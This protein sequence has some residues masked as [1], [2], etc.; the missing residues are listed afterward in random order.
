MRRE[1]TIN[2]D[3][4]V[5]SIDPRS[6]PTNNLD[7]PVAFRLRPARIPDVAPLDIFGEE[8][9]GLEQL[10]ALTSPAARHKSGVVPLPHEFQPGTPDVVVAAF[11]ASL[12]EWRFAETG[13]SH[14]LLGSS[15]AAAIT[16]AREVY[17][18]FMADTEQKPSVLSFI[19]ERFRVA[20]GFADVSDEELFPACYT[21]SDHS[22]PQRLTRELAEEARAGLVFSVAGGLGA[23]VLKPDAVS[24]AGLERGVA[25][26]WNGKAFTRAFDYR[27]MFWRDL[28]G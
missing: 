9:D 6:V 11:A 1:G 24:R 17:S 13:L 12:P 22:A 21:G 15:V 10:R 7:W 20:G 3:V 28:D 27:D 18:Q 19:V 5:A 16:L 2:T 8:S 23:V 4:S 14:M 25:L 26:E